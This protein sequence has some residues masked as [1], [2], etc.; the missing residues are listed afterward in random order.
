LTVLKIEMVAE[1]FGVS[2]PDLTNSSAAADVMRNAVVS[3][4]VKSV[5][6]SV[7]GMTK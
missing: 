4:C 5:R 3:V 6:E 7:R 1:P 2:V